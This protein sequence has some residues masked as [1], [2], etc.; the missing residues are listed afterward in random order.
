M[1]EIEVAFRLS[2]AELVAAARAMVHRRWVTKL[3][4]VFFSIYLVFILAVQ[5]GLTNRGKPLPTSTF[6]FAA[7]TALVV[8]VLTYFWPAITVQA[9]FRNHPTA[10]E[11]Q[12][13]RFTPDGLHMA[14]ANYSSTLKWSAFRRLVEDSAF[15]YFYMSDVVAVILPKRAVSE[16]VQ[17]QLRA[18]VVQWLPT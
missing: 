17:G 2:R 13:W 4:Y 5:I 1:S 18:A 15:F 10:F 6:V 11:H 7:G 16:T 12:T 3:V 14:A 9:A 8:L